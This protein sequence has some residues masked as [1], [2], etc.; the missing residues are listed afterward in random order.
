MLASAAWDLAAQRAVGSPRGRRQAAESGAGAGARVRG[1]A[2]ADIV[3]GGIRQ[4]HRRPNA[5]SHG[6]GPAPVR[7][8]AW[9]T[10]AAR[11]RD[12]GCRRRPAAHR[13]GRGR[14]E[15]LARPWRG[16]GG[17][18]VGWMMGRE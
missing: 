1:A 3:P 18:V 17:R 7:G 12:K 16:A 11:G 13:R 5:G 2:A 15:H 9:K 14:G 10:P 8:M 6:P 4:R